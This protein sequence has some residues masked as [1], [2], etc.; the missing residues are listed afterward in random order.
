MA[1]SRRA[2]LGISVVIVRFPNEQARREG[3]EAYT[4]PV[5]ATPQKDWRITWTPSNA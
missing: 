4:R 5:H 1:L 3:R 2:T